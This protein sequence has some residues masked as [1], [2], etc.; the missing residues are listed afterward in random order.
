MLSLL[1]PVKTYDV[2]KSRLAVPAGLRRELVHALALDTVTAALE[3]P[4]V[5]LVAVVTGEPSLSRDASALGCLVLPDEGGGDLNATIAAGAAR[6][7]DHD[8]AGVLLGDL[9]ALRSDELSAALTGLA[10]LGDGFVADAARTGTTLLV[11]SGSDRLLPRFG[12]GS[13][14]RHRA[15]G[16]LELDLPVPSLRRDVD[17]VEDL[18][19]AAALGVGRHTSPLLD[20]VRT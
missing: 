13:A 17:T 9:P 8:R 1:V 14:A 2:A 10:G 7:P 16:L 11:C 4:S 18:V 20:L 3:C 12:V 6:L 15:A 19:A 5:D